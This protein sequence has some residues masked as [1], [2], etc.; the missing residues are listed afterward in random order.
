MMD[1]LTSFLSILF[2]QS[3]GSFGKSILNMV[4]EYVLTMLS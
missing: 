3:T 1:F 4:A 2:G